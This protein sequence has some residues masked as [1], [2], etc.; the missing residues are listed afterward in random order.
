M[1]RQ[2]EEKIYNRGKMRTAYN[3]FEMPCKPFSFSEYKTIAEP[4]PPS[5]GIVE[6]EKDP[7]F[8]EIAR[9]KP[10]NFTPKNLRRLL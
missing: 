4:F 8:S 10:K 3:G 1:E 6:G 2:T 7:H 9:M 5:W